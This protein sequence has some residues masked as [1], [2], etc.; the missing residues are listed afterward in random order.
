MRRRTTLMLLGLTLL[1]PLMSGC[2]T[3]TAA[4]PI[5]A[6]AFKTD[7]DREEL[8]GSVKTVVTEF[9]ER[10]GGDRRR[11]GSATYDR[12]GALI[13]DEDVTPDFV[14]T[15]R[16]E[17]IDANTI[18]YRSKMGNSVVRCRY[19]SRGNILREETWYGG[20]IAGPADEITDFQ[21][22]ANGFE[23]QR[24]FL[25]P[26]GKLSG[27]FHYTRDAAGMVTEEDDWLNDPKS[28]HAHMLYRY[29]FDAR[30]NW[31]K[32]SE[33]RSGVPDDD[34]QFGTSGTLVRT[35]TYF[36][37]GGVAAAETGPRAH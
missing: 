31:V 12:A 37:D 2:A 22:D 14:K 35:I 3:K 28:P 10:S 20:K 11:L 32:R 16:P 27:A 7:R 5:S 18:L 29:E 8:K 26:Q 19:D 30:G 23:S 21:Y 9:E 33:T 34:H 13:E 4:P 1:V 24:N 25:G 6:P 15:R 36:D 17:R